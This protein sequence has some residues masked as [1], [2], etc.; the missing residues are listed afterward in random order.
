M[1]TTHRIRIALALAIVVSGWAAFQTRN[2]AVIVF[3]VVTVLLF[4][5]G[6]GRA[7]TIAG[8]VRTWHGRT[9]QVQVWGANPPALEMGELRLVNSWALGAGIHFYVAGPAG[10]P[11]HIK[12][13]QPKTSEILGARLLIPDAKYVQVRG[14]TMP[15]AA[16]TAFMMELRDTRNSPGC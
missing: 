14:Q 9:V 1:I 11:I 2:L 12:V 4:A 7:G 8:Q 5:T 16:T 15:R 13:A 6:F 3:L 10:R